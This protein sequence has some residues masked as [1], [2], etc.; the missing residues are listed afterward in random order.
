MIVDD[1]ADNLTTTRSIIKKVLRDIPLK[2]FEARDG[3]EAVAVAKAERPDLILMDIEM[4]VIGGIE[5]TQL[6][7]QDETLRNTVVIALTASAMTGDREEIL[8]AGCDD[9]LSRPA[10]PS[11]LNAMIRKWIGEEKV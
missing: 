4:P 10:E 5:A 1:H 11:D 7:K 2:L 8:A 9:Y 3:K 6:I